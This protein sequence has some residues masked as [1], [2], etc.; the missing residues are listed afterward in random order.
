MPS[1]VR[2][3]SPARARRTISL[4]LGDFIE[5]K[6][7]QR[8]AQFE[9]HVVRNIDDIVDRGVA[10]RF[11]TLAQP[12]RRRLHFHP[13]H[14][15]SRESRAKFR[16]FDR[17]ARRLRDRRRGFRE[18]RLHRLQRKAIERGGF[19]RDAVVAQAIR[20]IRG[21]FR[22]KHRARGGFFDRIHGGA[23]GG[24]PRAQICWRRFELDEFFE[25]IEKDFHFL[26]SATETGAGNVRRSEIAPANR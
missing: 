10:Q 11:E 12:I 13:A 18:F 23:G 26:I 1:S 3:F 15:A 24:K 16:R 8:L 20:A 22:I 14:H 19:T 9:H 2:S 6:G 21:Q 4:M 7:M 17:D 25:P 5:I